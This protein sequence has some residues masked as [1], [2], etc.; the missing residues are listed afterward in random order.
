MATRD[1]L[2]RYIAQTKRNQRRLGRKRRQLPCAEFCAFRW[3]SAICSKPGATLERWR[4][5]ATAGQ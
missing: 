4:L 1:D 3:L 5:A 2:E